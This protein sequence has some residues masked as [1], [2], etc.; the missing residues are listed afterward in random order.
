MKINYR[1]SQEAHVC[2]LMDVLTIKERRLLVRIHIELNLPLPLLL[3]QKTDNS[4][5]K[6]TAL[7]NGGDTVVVT[8][9][10]DIDDIG[11]PV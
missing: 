7:A 4:A 6:S 1:L 10:D 2:V 8:N 11:T 3:L 5:E 9:D